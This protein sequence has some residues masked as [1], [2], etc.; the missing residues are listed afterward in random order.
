[1][2]SIVIPMLNEIDA[3]ERCLRSL[4]EQ[5][6]PQERIEIVVVDGLSRDGS[7]EQVIELA[8][9]HPQIRLLDNPLRT[10]PRSLNLGVRAS[11]GEVVIILGAHT[12]VKS[13][14]V[15]RNIECMQSLKVLC[16]GGTQ[17]NTG[18]TLLQ[19]V[20]GQAMGSGFGIPTAPYRFNKKPRF[21]DTVVY[22]AYKK[23]LFDQVG[24]FDEKLHISEDAELN[25]R[26]RRAG[27]QIYFTPEIV[28]YYYPRKNL[29]QLAKQFFNYGIL[30]VNVIKK[31][32]DAIKP[33]HLLPPLF[34][35]ASSALAIIGFWHP[36]GWQ[37]VC[38]LWL[39]YALYLGL[40]SA[41]TARQNKSPYSGLLL[42]FV[43]ITMQISWAAGFLVGMIK[44]Y[45]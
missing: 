5:D 42:P 39:A 36:W 25:W 12:R 10:T 34:L 1:L 14:F 33:L 38:G 15:R 29:A 32:G 37:T 31:H 24:Y 17:I 3:I 19:R 30:R 35:L 18:D 43:F 41:L 21:V 20:I 22:A 4:F 27:H 2:V 9:I 44:T 26:I 11:R 23:E 13:D 40:A 8:K 28:S 16:V 6:Y 45:K 7:R